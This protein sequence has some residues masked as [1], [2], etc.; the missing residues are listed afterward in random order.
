MIE[1][2]DSLPLRPSAPLAPL[3]CV[4]QSSSCYS[5]PEKVGSQALSWRSDALSTRRWIR[6]TNASNMHSS[7]LAGV[8][9][10]RSSISRDRAY[11][12][13][14]TLHTCMSDLT[15]EIDIL[16]ELGDDVNRINKV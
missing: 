8:E 3:L 13:G 5:H 15:K 9:T 12:C 6:I 16:L 10:E 2:I 7:S 11:A 14:C 4:L 1:S